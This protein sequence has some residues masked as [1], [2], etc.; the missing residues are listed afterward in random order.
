[1]P[2]TNEFSEV[3]ARSRRLSLYQK[4]EHAVILILSALLA[5][6][7]VLAV[8]NPALKVFASIFASGFDPTD[9]LRVPGSLRNDLH[10]DYRSRIRTRWPVPS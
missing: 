3:R 8:W 2:L 1:M 4:F 9:L 7:L 6:L 10:G 5:V